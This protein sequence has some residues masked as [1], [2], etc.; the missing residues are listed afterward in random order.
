MRSLASL[1]LAAILSLQPLQAM[2]DDHGTMEERLQ[3]QLE[4]LLEDMGPT[5][6]QAL[7]EAMKFFGAFEGIDDPR[8]YEFPEILPNGDIVIRRR[9]DAPPYQPEPPSDTTDTEDAVNL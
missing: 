3:E 4:R 8:Y 5:L 2:A 6:D 9:P 7:E 1:T